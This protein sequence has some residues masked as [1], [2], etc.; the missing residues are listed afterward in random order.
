MKH[1]LVFFALLLSATFVHGQ[2]VGLGIGSGTLI[3]SGGLVVK[4]NPQNDWRFAGR[5]NVQLTEGFSIIQPSLMVAYQVV[6]EEKA[7]FYVGGEVAFNSSPNLII[8]QY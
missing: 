4:S 5:L 7:K 1:A 6:N 8:P 3:S 2:S